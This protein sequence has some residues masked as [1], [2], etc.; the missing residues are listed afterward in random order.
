[1]EKDDGTHRK[2]AA[3]AQGNPVDGAGS[4]NT[5]AATAT[6]AFIPLRFSITPS[7]FEDT[8]FSDIPNAGIRAGEII[9]WRAWRVRSRNRSGYSDPL[10]RETWLFGRNRTFQLRSIIT[11]H[12]WDDG[13]MGNAGWANKVENDVVR[14]LGVH[15]FK[16]KEATTKYAEPFASLFTIAIGQVALWGDV[17]EHEIGYRGEFAKVHSINYLI[18]ECWWNRRRLLKRLKETYGSPMSPGSR[19]P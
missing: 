4:P 6:L 15:A 3:Q 8:E 12:V 1:M 10:G 14:G 18:G 2:T 9:A 13:R 7:T 17:V 5:G 19:L 11:E 16:T